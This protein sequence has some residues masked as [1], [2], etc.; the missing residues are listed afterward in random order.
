MSDTRYRIATIPGDGV[1][2]DVVAAAR[3]AV[4]AASVAFRFG[5]DW[6]E[7]VAGGVDHATRGGD[8][9]G[10][11]PVSGDRDEA[12]AKAATRHAMPSC[13]RGATNATAT[14]LISAPWS[15]LTATR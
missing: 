11:H 14:P 1:G 7:I 10:T 2:P 12:V 9:L 15:L 13:W 3:T 6:T 8:D 4:D 5:V